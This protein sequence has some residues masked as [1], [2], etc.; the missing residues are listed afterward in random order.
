MQFA[1]AVHFGPGLLRGSTF[2]AI[3]CVFFK[4]DFHDSHFQQTE[5]PHFMLWPSFLLRAG[6]F[7][8][9]LYIVPR[10][11]FEV[12]ADSFAEMVALCIC[13]VLVL[14]GGSF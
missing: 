10:F 7:S 2:C 6:G 1:S 12:V 11:L 14:M 4:A 5:R 13:I 3:Y 9:A 8:G